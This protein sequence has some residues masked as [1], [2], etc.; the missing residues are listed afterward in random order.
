[1]ADSLGEGPDLKPW[2]KASGG[3]G[4]RT[5]QGPMCRA[6][7]NPLRV[8][9]FDITQKPAEYSV[10]G[11]VRGHYGNFSKWVGKP[12]GYKYPPVTIQ[13]MREYRA[14]LLLL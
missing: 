3:E 6:S 11:A 2:S 8:C 5:G 14:N 1:M 9:R 7:C 13:I 12:L 10:F 4:S